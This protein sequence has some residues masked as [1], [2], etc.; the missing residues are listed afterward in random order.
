MLFVDRLCLAN[1]SI[2]A[3]N[4]AVNAGM[5][6]W[7]LTFGLQ[8]LTEMS[9]IFV[10]QYNGAGEYKQ[11]GRPVWQM[12]WVTLAL[13]P[14]MVLIGHFGGPF[15]FDM[16]APGYE[17]KVVYFR[18]LLYFGPLYGVLGSLLAF[19]VG[20]GRTRVVTV[21][22]VLGNLVNITLDPLFIFGFEGWVEPMG[23]AGAA[24]AT[25]L[26]MLVQVIALLGY[27]LRPVHIQDLGAGE[28]RPEW[29]RMWSY[30]KVTSPSS[31]M[32]MLEMGGW[33]MFYALMAQVSELHILM[34]GI[35]QDFVILLLFFG[36]GLHKGVASVTGNL[37]GAKQHEHISGVLRQACQYCLAFAASFTVLCLVFPKQILG[38][39]L[40]HALE[41]GEI[42]GMMT[43]EEFWQLGFLCLLL[44]CLYLVIDYLRMMYC[45]VLGAAGD[46]NFLL[47][48]GISAIWLF[49]IVPTYYAVVL[50]GGSVQLAIAIWSSY[51]L[52]HLAI[53]IWRFRSGV[54]AKKDL[55]S[56]G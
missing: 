45:A 7:T 38:V 23:I 18:L 2:T 13:T 28:W 37:I 44:S 1:Y 55:L 30:L 51:A 27:F 20:Q 12:L 41:S 47:F 3:H 33:S 4:A 49:L 25:G 6:A 8:T 48:S 53:E 29:K 16:S 56:T 19:F 26:G 10:A 22:A 42:Q 15:V 34:A 36:V 40:K 46:T 24:I 11:L 39:M 21:V 14:L 31:L 32:A 5:V 52:L 9:E 50:K 43:R 54:W 17:E 35:C